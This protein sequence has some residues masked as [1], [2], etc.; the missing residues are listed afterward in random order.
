METVV[1]EI[2]MWSIH[3]KEQWLTIGIQKSGECM[4]RTNCTCEKGSTNQWDNFGHMSSVNFLLF[5]FSPE[6]NKEFT[7]KY[8][9]IMKNNKIKN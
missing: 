2:F 5:Y 6:K 8:G 3:T 1:S 7:V 9:M 4:Q